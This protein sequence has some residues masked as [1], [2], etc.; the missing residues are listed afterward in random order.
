MNGMQ[1]KA[2]RQRRKQQ[3]TD[4]GIP[5]DS[6]AWTVEDWADLYVTM[7]GLRQRIAKRHQE[8]Q[9]GNADG[10]TGRKAIR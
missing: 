10:S 5:R 4:D 3:Y 9:D 7:S 6:T 1:A 2:H 8:V